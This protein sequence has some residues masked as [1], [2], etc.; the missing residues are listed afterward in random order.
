MGGG[1]EGRRLGVSTSPGGLPPEGGVRSF[2]LT[3]SPR[4]QGRP[5][6]ICVMGPKGQKVSCGCPRGEGWIIGRGGGV[7]TPTLCLYQGDP[8][9][10][11]PEGLAGEPG[12]P[13]LP[14]PPGIGLPGTPVST[15]CPLLP[16]FSQRP[17]SLLA[18]VGREGSVPGVLVAGKGQR[19]PH[20]NVRA[21]GSPWLTLFLPSGG[22]RWP[23]RP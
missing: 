7:L 4:P 20:C 1:T 22:P 2:I 23:A 5:G 3:A 18:R 9:F 15:P 11:G 21:P 17:F 12:P 13:G 8:G 16:S 6:E 19:G 10:V 14:G